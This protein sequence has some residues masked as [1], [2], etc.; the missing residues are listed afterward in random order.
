M[1]SLNDRGD[2]S[3]IIK[4]LFEGVNTTGD[5]PDTIELEFQKIKARSRLVLSGFHL[6]LSSQREKKVQF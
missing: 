3:N 4:F 6:E 5:R 2:R 1:R